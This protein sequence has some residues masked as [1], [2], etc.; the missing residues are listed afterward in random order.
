[1]KL[2]SIHQIMDKKL[3]KENYEFF[4]LGEKYSY[5][6]DN[7]DIPILFN[8]FND[9]VDFIRSCPEGTK[10]Y[11]FNE[12]GEFEGICEIKEH[13]LRFNCMNYYNENKKLLWTLGYNHIIDSLRNG[14][15]I[16]FYKESKYD[17]D[18]SE[19]DE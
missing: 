9:V 19:I 15:I 6:K 18:D 17:G 1:M 8:K 3:I 11:E 4:N 10:F 13:S 14:L 5:M 7:G 16:P 2:N 12:K